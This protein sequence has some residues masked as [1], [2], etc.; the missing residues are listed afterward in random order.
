[1]FSAALWSRSSDR[2]QAQVTEQVERSKSWNTVLHLKQHLDVQAG[3]TKVTSRPALPALYI[4]N[5]RNCANLV[6]WALRAM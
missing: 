1:M 6:S 4:S 5:C 3:L 2:L